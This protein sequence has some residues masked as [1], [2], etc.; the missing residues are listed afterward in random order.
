L[1]SLGKQWKGKQNAIPILKT[2]SE[3]LIWVGPWAYLLQGVS[4]ISCTGNQKETR[5][6]TK[7]CEEKKTKGGEASS[8][9]EKLMRI[10]HNI[11]GCSKKKRQPVVERQLCK[12]DRTDLAEE[13][14]KR[15]SLRVRIGGFTGRNTPKLNRNA[16][17]EGGR[18]RGKK[19]E[20]GREKG[21]EGGQGRMEF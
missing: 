21:G 14:R 9:K 18:N 6:I 11:E 1:E 16:W 19:K 10:M 12:N 8:R 17:G 20:R 3:N 2:E 15:I 4:S 5:G 13:Q 7:Y